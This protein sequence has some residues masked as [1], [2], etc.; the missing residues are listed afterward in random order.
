MFV[1]GVIFRSFIVILC[2]LSFFKPAIMREFSIESNG[3][4]ERTALYFNGEQIGGVRQLMLHIS[5]QGDFDTIVVYEGTDKNIYTKNFFT[6]Y[7]DNIKKSEPSFS[8]E[9]A[10]HLRL[11]V[12]QSDGN[13][14]STMVYIDDVPQ[15]G[16]VDLLVHIERGDAPQTSGFAMFKKQTAPSTG[17]TFRAEVQYRNQDDTLSTESVF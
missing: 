14:E 10:E 4:L 6:D 3:T 11:L 1:C 17:A 9:D 7:L 15:D 16:I 8:E 5:E 2:F 13:L 12:V